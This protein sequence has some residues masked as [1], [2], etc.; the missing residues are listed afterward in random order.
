MTS[1]PTTEPVIDT[2]TASDGYC[3]RYRR[4]PPSGPARARVVCI[5]GIQ[6]HGGWY[7]RSCRFLSQAG[8][9]VAFLDRRG[10]GLNEPDRGDA[11]SFRRLL[12]DLVEF[13]QPLRADG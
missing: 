2:A 13:L 1:N 11:P 9:E 6:S 10:S 4:Y 5:H 12:D 8:F 7:T 3:W